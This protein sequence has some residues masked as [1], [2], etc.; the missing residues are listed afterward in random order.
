[1]AFEVR[2]TAPDPRCTC[3]WREGTV[4]AVQGDLEVQ[5]PEWRRLNTGQGCPVHDPVKPYPT[6][7]CGGR[8]C[9]DRIIWAWTRQQKKIPVNAQPDPEGNIIL[10]WGSTGTD[11]QARVL[12]KAQMAAAF[13]ATLY[14]AHWSGCP[15]AA[16]FRTGRR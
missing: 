16:R 9:T 5:V 7:A 6:A 11:V 1:M 15:D 13:G 2:L 4:T 12:T 8:N 3:Y 10:S 14:T